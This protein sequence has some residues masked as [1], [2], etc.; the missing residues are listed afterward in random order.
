MPSQSTSEDGDMAR[1]FQE[2]AKFAH[3]IHEMKSFL[4]NALADVLLEAS[5]LL[6]SWNSNSPLSNKSSTTS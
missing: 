3:T 5:K 2:L 1:A 6:Q 4:A